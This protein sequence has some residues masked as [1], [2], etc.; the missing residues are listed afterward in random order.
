M[1]KLSFIVVLFCLLFF[2]TMLVSAQSE[3][4]IDFTNLNAVL[5]WLSG[6]GAV[7][8]VGWVLA[9]FLE[10]MS[11]WNNLPTYIKWGVPPVFSV[12]LAFV[13]QLLLKQEI[14][15]AQIQPYF[16]L[17][18]MILLTYFGSQVGHTATRQARYAQERYAE[19]NKPRDVG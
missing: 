4:P 6:V 17:V 3:T 16:S 11:W 19:V 10:K 1:K 7:T 5:A 14:L 9:N 15:L 2:P 13:A 12:L 18:V 8:A